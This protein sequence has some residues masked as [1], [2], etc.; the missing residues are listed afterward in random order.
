MRPRDDLVFPMHEYQRRLDELRQRMEQSGVDAMITTTPENICYLSGFES[1]GHYYF[2]ALIIPLEGEPVMVPRKLED[3]GVQALTWIEISR[4]YQDFE[5]PMDKLRSTLEEIGLQNRSIG[6]EKKCWFFTAAQQEQLFKSLPQIQFIDCSGMVEAGRVIKSDYEIEL[7]KKAA[8]TA[9]AGMRAG[10]DAIRP[11]VTEND[12]AAEIHYAMIKAGSEWPSIAPFV[13][14]G[15]RGAIGHATWAG[16]KIEPVDTVMLEVGG[17]LKRYHAA[18]MRSVFIGDPAAELWE[19]EKVVREAMEATMAAIR[20]GVVAHDVDAVSRQIIGKSI[21]GGTQASRSAY[22]IGI[23][24]PPDWGEGQI[25]SIQPNESRQ[26]EANMT[27]HLIPWVQVPG[28]GGISF[29]E[30]IR[31]TKNGCE[32]ITDFDRKIYV[33]E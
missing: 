5:D 16:R 31:V 30:T 26:L 22:S 33:K 3:S 15:E 2:Q 4:P 13:A 14:S 10:I 1:P 27:F 8:R 18:L 9:E 24:L 21:F 29:S 19:G 7:M 20:P 28:K 25:L 23:G 32:T 17:C 6:F 12:I 11:G